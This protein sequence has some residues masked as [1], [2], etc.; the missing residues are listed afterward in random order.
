M[1]CFS[2]VNLSI[3]PEK[4]DSTIKP[5]NETKIQNET[6]EE[7]SLK[8]NNNNDNIIKDNNLNINNI[9]FEALKSYQ[10]YLKNKNYKSC[11]VGK[12]EEK[13]NKKIKIIKINQ[14]DKNET[15]NDIK[16][17][18]AIED[19]DVDINIYKKYI[20]KNENNKKELKDPIE[21]ENKS[22]E[23]NENNNNINDSGKK[24]ENKKNES[25]ILRKSIEERIT[26]YNIN[27]KSPEKNKE[28][29][30]SIC[31]LGKS[32]IKEKND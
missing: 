11:E 19:M 12:E 27:K 10:Y 32:Y 24:E 2:S 7:H 1:G 20:I 3:A 16:N 31:N 8:I 22:I 4:K 15:T 17:I 28:I 23:K 5:L 6:Y 29:D 14:K 9:P 26:K 25:R 18:N 30:D 21:E 13:Q